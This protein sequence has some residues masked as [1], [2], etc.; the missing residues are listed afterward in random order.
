MENYS[1]A[2]GRAMRRLRQDTA[3]ICTTRRIT[4]R[5]VKR[6]AAGVGGFGRDDSPMAPLCS[7]AKVSAACTAL[8]YPV[9]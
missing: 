5:F 8:P 1:K 9:R 2:V 6:L 4:L 7:G 3:A